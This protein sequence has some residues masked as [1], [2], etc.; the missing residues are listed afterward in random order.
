MGFMLKDRLGQYHYTEGTDMPFRRHRMVFEPNQ[1][2]EGRF[3]FTMP[4]LIQGMY[5]INVAIAEGIGEA[6]F[7]HHWIHDAIRLE[8]LTSRVIHGIGG[9]P[10]L[11]ISIQCV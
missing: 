6:H 9:V 3:R 1:V 10:D 2:A 7:Q 5:T 4:I 11:E 8:A